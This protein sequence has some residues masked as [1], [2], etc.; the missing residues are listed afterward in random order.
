VR[1]NYTI[2]TDGTVDNCMVT[3]TSGFPRLDE[4]ACILVQ[5]WTFK[6]AM[7]MG[8]NPIAVTIPAEVVFALAPGRPASP[9]AA[10][11][12]GKSDSATK[13]NAPSAT[14][15]V[16]VTSH[17]V[18]VDDYPPESVSLGEQGKVQIR[19]TIG[20]DGVVSDC[21]VTMSSGIPRLD[22]GACTMVKSK[23]QF[24]PA[25]QNGHAVAVAI[26]A[27]VIFALK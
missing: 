26:P 12:S 17:A 20:T 15:P 19:Y 22:D 4:A 16:A 5:K 9:P 21:V 14:A 7:V 8:G 23:W 18:T 25:T 24:K 6:P 1:V 13:K 2:D 27:E 10:G 3:M 11:A